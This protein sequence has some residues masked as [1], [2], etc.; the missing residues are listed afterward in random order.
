MIP[1]MVEMVDRTA[2]LAHFKIVSPHQSLAQPGLDFPQ[3]R[4]P[5]SCSCLDSGQGRG[6]RAASAVAVPCLNTRSPDFDHVL[7]QQTAGIDKRIRTL[8]PRQVASL[9]QHRIAALPG[10]PFALVQRRRPV[11]RFGF[12]Q[13][14]GQFRKVGCNEVRHRQKV[15]QR[16]LG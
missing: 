4:L 15:T 9:D 10:Q 13:Q 6:Q 14:H 16:C 7:T 8:R 11:L 5:I 2:P 3:G 1:E 12:P